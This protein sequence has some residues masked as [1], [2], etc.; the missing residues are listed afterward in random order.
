MAK[1]AVPTAAL[2]A[3]FA[4]A[5]A[6]PAASAA[7]VRVSHGLSLF[8]DLKYGPDFAHQPQPVYPQGLAGGRPRF[9]LRHPDGRVPGRSLD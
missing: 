9:S 3:V 4:L 5:L 6:T 8:G 2:A 1:I 7:E